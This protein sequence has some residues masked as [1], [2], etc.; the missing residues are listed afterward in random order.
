MFTR[1]IVLLGVAFP[2]SLEFPEIFS[3]F[4]GY[5]VLTVREGV[6]LVRE[7]CRRLCIDSSSFSIPN[8]Y[9]GADLLRVPRSVVFPIS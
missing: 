5:S 8:P 7:L 1:A 2:I 4:L 6:V 9:F 3:S